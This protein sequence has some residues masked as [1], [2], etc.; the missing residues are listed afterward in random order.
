MD[1]QTQGARRESRASGPAR[2]AGARCRPPAR[3]PTR[4][5][6]SQMLGSLFGKTETRAYISMERKLFI[7]IFFMVMKVRALFL[8]TPSLPGNNISA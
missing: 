6:R 1:G 2:Q 7:F 4:G 3:P 5:H 8:L